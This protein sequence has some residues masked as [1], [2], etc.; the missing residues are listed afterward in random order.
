MRKPTNTRALKALDQLADLTALQVRWRLV[1]LNAPIASRIYRMAQAEVQKAAKAQWEAYCVV[2]RA[3]GRDPEAD[4][5]P[6]KQ[7]W[8]KGA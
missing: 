1:A 8:D 6:P 7:H 5:P 4:E 2:A 3:L